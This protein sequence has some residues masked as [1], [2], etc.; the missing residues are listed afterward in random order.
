MQLE[1]TAYYSDKIDLGKSVAR[2]RVLGNHPSS[3]DYQRRPKKTTISV[4]SGY[5]PGINIYSI[6][7][8]IP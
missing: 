1:P 2:A 6:A 8:V 4:I 7:L 3:H 5:D